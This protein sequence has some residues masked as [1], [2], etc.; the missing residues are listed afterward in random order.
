MLRVTHQAGKKHS[1]M[2]LYQ[3]FL[4]YSG[5]GLSIL[6]QL[7]VKTFFD[8]QSSEIC[9]WSATMND[10]YWMVFFTHK[11]VWFHSV[12]IRYC[13]KY[14]IRNYCFMQLETNQKHVLPW[15][16]LD[17]LHCRCTCYWYHHCAD[18]PVN[19]ALGGVAVQSTTWDT[20][21]SP[22]NAIDG[23]QISQY[24]QWSC[25]STQFQD[26]PWW[27]LDLRTQYNISTIEIIRR[28]DCCLSELE[29]AEIRIG[30]SLENNGNSNPR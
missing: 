25:I 5:G 11:L 13:T 6:C 17:L 23:K 14:N 22:N 15:S 1:I 2:N 26:S 19:V 30:N 18:S 4:F 20:K 21:L 29:G 7:T 16:A 27:R 12:N 24:S 8:T 9:H 28:S 10:F 3:C